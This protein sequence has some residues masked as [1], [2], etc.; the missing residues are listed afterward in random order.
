MCFFMTDV[1]TIPDFSDFKNDELY[2]IP[3]GGSGE[4]GT[5]LNLYRWNNH[6]L[7]VDL[8]VSFHNGKVHPPGTLIMPDISFI[9]KHRK[10]LSGII[11][12]HAHEDHI[13]A[14][15][16]LWPRLRC[17]VYATPFAAAFLRAKLRDNGLD[18]DVVDILT[19][20][21]GEKFYVGPYFCRM[22]PITHSIPESTMVEIH[23]PLGR[24]VHSG[25]WKID[26]APGVGDAIE[27][28]IYEEMGGDG[29]LLNVTDSTNANV[30]GRSGDEIEVQEGLTQLFSRL[31]HRIF[32][33]CFASNVGRIRSI[34][35]AAQ[36]NGRQVVLAGRSLWRFNRIARDLGF[37]D[38]LMPFAGPEELRRIKRSEVVV[39]CTG[40]QGETAAALSRIANGQHPK[41]QAMPND[42][43][44]FSSRAIPGNEDEIAELLAALRRAGQEI[45]TQ[46]DVVECI[47]SSGHP[48]ADE[49]AELYRWLKPEKVLPVHGTLMHQQ[50][51][52]AIARR[53]GIKDVLVPANGQVIRVAPGAMEIMGHVTNGKMLHFQ[54]ER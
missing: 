7:M 38:D 23:T 42:H 39:I 4:F 6:W 50:A 29:V 21:P 17:P 31:P 35:L 52:E 16:Y 49:V 5:N 8:G 40:S 48:C 44:V 37:F 12:T 9:E 36:A 18:E 11:I 51:N 19:V 53:E 14:V 20:E 13:G 26:Y 1:Q 27:P 46:D 32:V 43:V 15:A 47:Y 10:S 41:I 45:L 25:D 28:E 24:I 30:P 34:A 3:L 33:S 22:T 54:E 2:F